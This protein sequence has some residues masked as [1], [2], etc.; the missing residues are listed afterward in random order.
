[1]RAC[2]D[3]LVTNWSQ[4]EYILIIVKGS[5]KG[6]FRTGYRRVPR[7]AIIFPFVVG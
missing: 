5:A 4:P 2:E 6:L 3:G 7:T 1:M